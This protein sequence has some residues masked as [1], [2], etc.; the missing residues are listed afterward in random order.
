MP[1]LP[2]PFST[3]PTKEQT[4]TTCEI[5]DAIFKDPQIKYG[6]REFSKLKIKEVITILEKR[7]EIGAKQLN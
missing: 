5:I 7:K 3:K 4:Q 2:D 1:K 6:L